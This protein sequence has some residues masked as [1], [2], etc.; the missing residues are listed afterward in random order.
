MSLNC[1]LLVRPRL[2]RLLQKTVDGAALTLVRAPLGAGKSVA[3]SMAFSNRPGTVWID[4]RPWHRDAFVNAAVEAVRRVRP[5]FG[6][7]TLGALEAGASAAH[8]GSRFAAELTHVAEPLLL[9]VDNVQVFAGDTAFA[10]FFQAATSD[11]PDAVRVVVL[12]RTLP[13]IALGERLARGRAALVE[14]SVFAFDAGE[15]RDLAALAG[16][17]FDAQELAAIA[18]ATEGWATGVALALTSAQHPAASALGPQTIAVAY[19]TEELL[20]A[21]GA[22]GLEFLERTAVFETLDPHVLERSPAFFDARAGIAGLRERGALITELDGGAFRIHPLLRELALRRLAERG[23]ESSAHYEAANAYAAAGEIGAALFHVQAS[24]NAKAAATFLRNHAGAAV[25]TGHRARTR[26]VAARIDANGPDGYVRWFVEGL[27]EKSRGSLQARSNFERAASGAIACEDSFVAFGARA[28]VLEHDMGRLA[29]VDEAALRDLHASA[30]LLG[31]PERAAAAV[32]EGWARAIAYDFSSAL[33]AIV[34]LVHSADDTI[35]FNAGVL[36]AYAQTALG[37]IDEA[38]ETLDGLVASLE[39]D[40]RVVLQTLTL[41]WF[42]RLALVWGRT[43]AAGDAAAAAHRLASALDLRADEAALYIALAELATHRG[44]VQASVSFAELARSR[45]G[46]A[47]YAADVDRV[48]AF[49]EIALARAAFLGHDNAVARDLALRAAALPAIPSAQKAVALV[50][51]AMYTLLC[52]PDESSDSIERA[53]AAVRDAVPVDAADAVAISVAADILAFL[54]AANGASS[55]VSLPAC[56]PFAALLQHRRGLVTLE[57]AGVAVGNARRGTASAVPFDTAIELLTRDGPRFEA[58]LA[59]AY[60]STFIKP[61]RPPERAVPD[62][63][64]TPREREIL[65]LLVDGLTNKEIAQ[66]LTVS[67]R[68]IETHVERVLGKL[69][70]G[71]RSR[72]IAKAL[73]LGLVSLD[74]TS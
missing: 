26:A 45:A 8:V 22:S 65:E 2:E 68:T 38:E 30:R 71:S 32:L 18:E 50:E 13:D 55:E 64:L 56:E 12:G 52:D 66:R 19:L 53:R 20:P 57:L 10:S 37:A 73:R 74:A 3:A 41:V 42:A 40:D 16:S 70:V 60:A 39:N 62:L 5:E 25:A 27:I 28:Q 29:F 63:D 7:M 15:I 54:N 72:A 21:L 61:A 11:L 31:E 24:A 6:R 1:E 51:A 33:E 34:P 44:D 43:N 17:N 67:P 47:W 4:A 58:R 36:R 69:E 23:A 35:R 46:Q 14:D 48:R 59:R 49:A 9:I